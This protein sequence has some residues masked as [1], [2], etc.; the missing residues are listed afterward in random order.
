MKSICEMDATEV[1]KMWIKKRITEL[2]YEEDVIETMMRE[3]F[4]D[5]VVIVSVMDEED[6]KECLE[7]GL[8]CK[9][10][11][12]NGS[13][14]PVDAFFFMVFSSLDKAKE[15]LCDNFLYSV[16]DTK[17]LGYCDTDIE[18]SVSDEEAAK[19]LDIDFDEWDNTA[20]SDTRDFI[21]TVVGCDFELEGMSVLAREEC[22]S[23]D[24]EPIKMSG[25][26]I[27]LYK[28]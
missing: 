28:P 16:I 6:A 19:I 26:V 22:L 14:N 18:A 25:C 20:C 9:E 10:V 15:I 17:F 7:T 27:E 3:Y 13:W 24:Y 8:I 4:G 11:K 5:K 2:A 12:Y 21:S 1:K 23:D